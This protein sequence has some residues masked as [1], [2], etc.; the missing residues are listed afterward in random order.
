[1]EQVNAPQTLLKKYTLSND[2]K[3]SPSN[4]QLP[5]PSNNFPSCLLLFFIRP[6]SALLL[7]QS[8]CLYFLYLLVS[9][10][11]SSLL[12]SFLPSILSYLFP[13]CLF[14]VAQGF[15]PPHLG[16]KT[17]K[18]NAVT[19]P[20]PQKKNNIANPFGHCTLDNVGSK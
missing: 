6:S 16:F 1:M 4:Q 5:T 3:Y 7:V 11:F 19:S 8:L 10:L 20:P 17:L 18:T 14:S 2:F 13:V 15:Q 9:S 12:P